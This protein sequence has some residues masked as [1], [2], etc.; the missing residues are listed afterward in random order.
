[1]EEW[2]KSA[3]KFSMLLFIVELSYQCIELVLVPTKSGAKER[4]ETAKASLM[5]KSRLE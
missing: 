3:Q 2:R 4:I 5:R 1:M